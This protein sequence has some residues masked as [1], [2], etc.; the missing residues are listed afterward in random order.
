MGFYSKVA[1]A[2]LLLIAILAGFANGVVL[3]RLIVENDTAKTLSLL[4]ENDLLLRA[5]L[6]CFLFIA[7]LDGVVAWALYILFKPINLDLSL[8]AAWLRLLYTAVFGA[9]LYH[10]A[11]L[12]EILTHEAAVD[13]VHFFISS[14]HNGSLISLLFFA[15][16]LFI[17]GYLIIRSS[18]YVPKFIGYL[19]VLAALA[20]ATGSLA[21]FLLLDYANVKSY[22]LLTAAFCGV[23]GELSLAFWLMLKGVKLQPVR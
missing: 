14:F 16:H 9:S 12:V 11:L 13:Q 15:F 6:V 8:L 10:F 7:L 21:H 19:L 18:G 22:F 1:G 20:C 23:L 17:L 3:N 4:A 2:G 5:G